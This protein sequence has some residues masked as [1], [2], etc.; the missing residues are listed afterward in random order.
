MDPRDFGELFGL[1]ALAVETRTLLRQ[2][3]D[4]EERDVL[5]DQMTQVVEEESRELRMRADLAEEVSRR[6][7]A[8]CR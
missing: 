1:L 3:P 2:L 5:I 8:R 4:D 7:K 6:L